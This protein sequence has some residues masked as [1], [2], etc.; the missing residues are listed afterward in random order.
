MNLNIEKD[1]WQ[2]GISP[3]AGIDEAG[4]GPLAGPVVAAAVVL[5]PEFNL[6]GVGDSK[7]LTALR[8]ENLYDNIYEQAT[9]IGIGMVH[10]R[11]IDRF[12]ILQATYQAMRQ[13]IGQLSV[14]PQYLLVDGL[15][16]D[17]Q[18]Y[19]Q[20]A[21]VNGDDKVLSIA[22]ASIIAK[23]TRDR[24]MIQYDLVY[25]EFGF[26]GHKGYGTRKHME[27]LRQFGATP[28]HRRSFRPVAENLPQPAL[29]DNPRALGRLGEQLAAG[30]LIKL[31]YQLAAMN[32]NVP[33]VGEIDIIHQEGDTLVFSEVKT[34]AANGFLGEPI[35][36][37]D[38]RKRD[39]LLAAAGD[40]LEQK[41]GGE[42]V[43]FDVIS[44]LFKQGK[45]RIKRIKGGLHVL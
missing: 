7:K 42:K 15:P 8:R 5:S 16:A 2:R 43:R 22:A 19:P 18:H 25:P 9:S 26:A 35:D 40:Y 29:P 6:D 11:G 14:R 38:I 4:R 32:F 44:V 24:L 39:R 1:Y 33:G 31:G 45:P 34:S 28:L 10:E 41:G 23:V 3:V 27:A 36:S 12:N 13:A 30:G 21:I 37:I 17:L 20:Q